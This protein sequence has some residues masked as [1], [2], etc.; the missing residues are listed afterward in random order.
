MKRDDEITPTHG[1]PGATR[2]SASWG[3]WLI[4]VLSLMTAAA[5]GYRGAERL[6][7][8]ERE[9]Q[10]L[11]ASGRRA[12]AQLERERQVIE[13]RVG[14]LEQQNRILTQQRDELTAARDELAQGL[15]EKTAA[16]EKLKAE[17][18]PAKRSADGRR[19]R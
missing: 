2:R 4:L 5:F 15:Q 11:R 8:A 19:R 14:E 3:P 1:A 12:T 7:E 17:R 10:E 13:D 16:L 18:I 6:R 9:L